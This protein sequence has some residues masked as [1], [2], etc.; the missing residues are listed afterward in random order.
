MKRP[1]CWDAQGR[2]FKLTY[3]LPSFRDVDDIC[4]NSRREIEMW[5]ENNNK[6]TTFICLP[7]VEFNYRRFVIRL[8][9]NKYL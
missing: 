9:T 1:L 2:Y 4:W 6:I 3:V 5:V 8:P 7:Y